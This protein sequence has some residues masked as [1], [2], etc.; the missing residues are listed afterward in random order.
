MRKLIV[1]LLALALVIAM[2]VPAWAITTGA[3]DFEAGKKSAQNAAQ[4]AITKSVNTGW[5]SRWF[6][7][8]WG[9]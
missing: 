4:A 3:W 8:R 5:Q 6:D 9:K 2:T 1:I 7:W